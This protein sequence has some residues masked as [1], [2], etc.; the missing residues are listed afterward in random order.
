MGDDFFAWAFENSEVYSVKS[1]YRAL[2][3]QK[4]RTALE[5]GTATGTSQTDDQMWITLWKLKV[6]PK[7]RVF[8]WEW[9]MES[10]LMKLP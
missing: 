3:T 6:M 2:V 4:E 10:C 5:K 7:A 8:W 9:F 1:A